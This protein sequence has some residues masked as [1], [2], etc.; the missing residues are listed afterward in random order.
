MDA[1]LKNIISFNIEG[2]GEEQAEEAM[3]A[4]MSEEAMESV[5]DA[6]LDPSFVTNITTPVIS[7]TSTQT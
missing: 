5:E 2:R 6:E 4:A 3:E 1:G 7:Q